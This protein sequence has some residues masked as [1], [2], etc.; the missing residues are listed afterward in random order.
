M[1]GSEKLRRGGRRVILHPRD[2]PQTLIPTF[3]P[4]TAQRSFQ[5]RS[6]THGLRAVLRKGAMQ[7][8]S[9]V[10]FAVEPPASKRVRPR[11]RRNPVR[12]LRGL[13]P[14]SAGGDAK[15]RGQP[16]PRTRTSGPFTTPARRLPDR[17][18]QSS[19]RRQQKNH[20]VECQGGASFGRPKLV[21]ENKLQVSPDRPKE[22]QPD[23]DLDR[24]G[25]WILPAGRE[26]V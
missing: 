23:V 15:R 6:G 14:R 22:K 24:S 20:L 10:L 1:R 25:Q 11:E 18:S 13:R 3:D 16:P 4:M 26:V 2:E 21:A 19:A 12:G 9:A 5:A 7:T 8:A 17:P